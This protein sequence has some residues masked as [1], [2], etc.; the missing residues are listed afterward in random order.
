MSDLGLSV[1]RTWVPI[2]VGF[3]IG[4]VVSFGLIDVSAA[5]QAGVT[6][7]CIAAAT[8]IYYLGVRW[9]ETKVPQLGWLLGVPRQPA[10]EKGK[11]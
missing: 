8:A 7:W 4:W 11:A 1:I 6:A 3:V 2:G 10:Y 5:D 9:A